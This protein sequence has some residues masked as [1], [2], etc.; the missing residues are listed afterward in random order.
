M[1]TGGV[2]RDTCGEVNGFV[3]FRKLDVKIGNK[4]VAVVIAYGSQLE[5][6]CKIEIRFCD[7]CY[8]HFLYSYVNALRLERGR[9]RA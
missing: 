2:V 9:E 5:R 4:R 6:S 8:V 1:R 7:C 3:A